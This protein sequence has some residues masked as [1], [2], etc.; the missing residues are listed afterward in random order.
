MSEPSFYSKKNSESCFKHLKIWFE[1]SAHD[2]LKY[3]FIFIYWCLTSEA[4]LVVTK[5]HLCCKNMK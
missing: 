3:P 4:D 2:F 1:I 5:V